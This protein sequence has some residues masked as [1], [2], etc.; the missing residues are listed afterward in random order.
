MNQE[1]LLQREL[2]DELFATVPVSLAVVNSE[3]RFTRVNGQMS[4]LYGKQGAEF[5]G[6]TVAEAIPEQTHDI[7]PQIL[8]ALA[9]ESVRGLE[10]PVNA[11]GNDRAYKAS[12]IPIN[13]GDGTAGEVLI[14]LVEHTTNDDVEQTLRLTHERLD[15]TLEGTRA[16]IFEWNSGD[17]ELR[18]SA[19]MGPLFGR[20]RGWTPPGY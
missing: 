18:W 14:M 6:L 1:D 20:E 13:N 15:L 3:L 16:G 12:F 5:T 8:R 4:A 9:G 2:L 11:A 17:N 7:E 19:G 10:F